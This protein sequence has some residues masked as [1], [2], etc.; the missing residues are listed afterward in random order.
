MSDNP[1]HAALELAHTSGGTPAEVIARAHE[2]HAFL[3][4]GA[5]PAKA[6]TANKT[7]TTTKATA[8][9]GTSP[10]AASGKPAQKP[11]Q[12]PNKAPGG[13]HTA[14]EVR[15]V[16]RKLAQTNKD[17]AVKIVSENGGGANKFTEVKPEY[18]D[19]LYEAISA[20]LENGDSGGGGADNDFV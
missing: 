20:E 10:K 13:K 15:D 14:D 7:D 5:A 2:Y 6:A 16:L 4:G 3:T 8:A 9:S 17:L 19:A 12:Q 1:K 11:A 18:Y